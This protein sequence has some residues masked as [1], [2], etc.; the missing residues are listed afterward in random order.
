MH[1]VSIVIV[2]ISELQHRA[3]TQQNSAFSLVLLHLVANPCL[4]SCWMNLAHSDTT[5]Y[6]RINKSYKAG[7]TTQCSLFERKLFLYGN[8]SLSDVASPIQKSIHSKYSQ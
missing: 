4:S 6:F 7:L 1:L 5:S 2:F 8:L 3:Q